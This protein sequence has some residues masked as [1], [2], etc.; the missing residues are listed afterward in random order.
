M[1]F[2]SDFVAEIRREL[3]ERPLDHAALTAAAQAAPTAR[4]FAST[5]RGAAAADGVALIAEVKRA[6]P[7]AG[8]IAVDVDPVQ[9]AIAYDRGGAAVISVLTEPRHFGGSL[10]DLR[11]VRAAVQHPVL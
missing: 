1:G 11:A 3:A 4:P 6:S 2:L 8:Q 10:D 5:L 7:S 9:Q